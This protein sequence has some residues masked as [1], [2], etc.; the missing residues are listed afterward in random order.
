MLAALFSGFAVGQDVSAKPVEVIATERLTLRLGEERVELPLFTSHEL[1]QDHPGVTRLVVG[2]HGA[3]RRADV[4][5]KALRQDGE[6]SGQLDSTWFIAPQFLYRHDLDSLDNP[7][8][9]PVWRSMGWVRGD[10]AR[11]PDNWANYR[12]GLSS[13]AVLDEV[14]LHATERCPD[15]QEIAI[16]GHSAG[17]QTVQRY[18]ATTKLMQQ[19]SEDDGPQ[20]RFLMANP[21]G[22]LYFDDRRPAPESVT[23]YALPEAS[24]REACPGYNDWHWGL[25]GREG[26][27]AWLDAEAIT[28]QYLCADVLL[29]SGTAD[30]VVNSEA[31][32]GSCEAMLQG[33]NRHQR[34]KSFHEYITRLQTER[35]LAL[36]GYAEVDSVGHQ[37]WK[38]LTSQPASEY[39]FGKDSGYIPGERD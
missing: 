12:S 22:Y 16:A 34:A 2:I 19:F 25:D 3:T 35:G 37:L 21:A 38:M 11:D 4:I 10:D 7:P 8:E 20:L 15:L 39:L 32:S 29:V 18:A 30:T 9:I 36:H 13:Y 24:A 26:Y 31:I 23:D 6:R 1:Y 33:M 5:Y 14:I 27:V 17:G 28:E